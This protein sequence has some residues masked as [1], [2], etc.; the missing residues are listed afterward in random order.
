MRPTS[1]ISVSLL[2]AVL[3]CTGCGASYKPTLS[4]LDP[5]G[6]NSR[7]ATIGTVTV[8][9]EEYASLEKALR[10]FDTNLAAAGVLPILLLIE[11]NGTEPIEVNTR[12]IS[13]GWD[14][15]LR[16]LTAQEA[17]KKAERSLMSEAAGWGFAAALSLPIIA[18]PTAAALATV[19]TTMVNRQVTQDFSRKGFSEA[20]IERG[21]YRSGFL[22]YQLQ[23]GMTDLNGLTLEL[24]ARKVRTNEAVV[25]TVP[26]PAT[27]R[28]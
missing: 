20:I 26:L 18:I 3:L 8:Y 19:D 17:A 16:S 14:S 27:P 5:V 12:D 7:K 4:R 13:V 2:T 11:N 10:A 9:V 28:R 21:H 23:N 25:V 24:K 22:F 6:L 15:P 1:T